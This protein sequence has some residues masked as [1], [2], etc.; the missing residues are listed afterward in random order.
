MTRSVTGVPDGAPTVIPRLFCRDPAAEID[1]CK[2][3][4]L[5]TEVVRR[6]GADGTVAH[7][8]ISIGRAM[9]M[10]ESEWPQIANRAPVPDGSSPVVLYVYVENVDE[11]V[12][13][14]T[15]AGA[16]ILMAP[17]DQFWGDRTGWVMDL[18]GHVWTIASRIEE[19]TEEERQRRLARLLAEQKTTA[20]SDA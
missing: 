1:F 17:A 8:L 5:A 14:A 7:A 15:A 18:S 4:F 16:R 13:R 19:S 11:A 3:T 12:S 6:N 20:A 10:I 9:V 2:R